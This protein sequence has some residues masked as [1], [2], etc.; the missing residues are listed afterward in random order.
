MP[1]LC[2]RALALAAVL[3]A[4]AVF[5]DSTA[6]RG[7]LK[8]LKYRLLGPA[9][10]G[11]VAR[12]AG[13]PGDPLTYY[14]ATASGGVWKSEDGGFGWKPV[15]DDQPIAS[16]GSI[17]V[18]PS[19]PGVV[20]VG[21]GEANIRG[22]VAPGDGIY[23]SVDAGKTWT[24]VLRLEGQ[25]GKIAVHPRDPDVAFA[26]VL[27][28]AFGPN[29]ERGVYRTRDGGKT[30][31]LVLKKDADTGAS[32]VAIDP[33]NPSVVF[34]GLWQ[35]RRRP[36]QLTSG[37]PGSGLYVSRDGG[38]TWRQLDD[39]K[40]GLPEGIWGKVGVAVAPSDPR[41]V[42][43]LIEAEAGGLFRS[44]DGGEKWT[45]VN[46]HH[47][48]R[49]RAWYYTTLTVDPT[50]ADVVWF[51][52]VHLL[53][54]TDGG[55]SLRQVKGPHH[56]DHHDAWV[57]PADPRRV[58]IGND[59]G[60]DLSLNGGESWFA[61]RLPLGQFYHVSVDDSVPYRV[62]GAMQD[63]GTA[64]ARSNTLSSDGITLA[65]WTD[66]GGGEAGHTASQPGDPDVVYAGEYLGYISRW[67]RALQ[68]P[69]D[70]SAY[71]MNLSGHGDEDA[72]YRFQWTAPIATSPH[73]PKVVYH[74][75]NVLL[76]TTD[77]GQSWA[78]I[79]P[80]LT[81]NDK[82]RQKWTGGPITGDNTGVEYYCT[83]FAIAESPRQQ[84][85]I[86]VGSDDGLVQLTRDGGGSWTNVTPKGFP[87]W[88]TISMI[89]PSPFDAAT[90]YVVVDAHR[91]D[92]LRPYL[93]KTGDYGRS[94]QSLAGGLPRDVYLHAV[95]ED[96]K[97]RGT[98]Y[99]GTE[100]GVLFSRDDGASWESLKLNLPTVAVHD[101]Q[102]KGDD[103]VLGT[104]GR[105]LWILDDLTPVRG[106]TRSVS[107]APVHLFPPA[108]AVRWRYHG[109]F[110]DEGPGSNPPAAAV[111][112][113]WL[114]A[115]A[116][117]VS[118][119]VLDAGGQVIRSLTSKPPEPPDEE[120]DAPD[121]PRH[122]KK[123]EPL[124][125]GPGLHRVRWDLRHEG[126]RR[127][128]RIKFEGADPEQGPLAVPGTY[129]LRLTVDDQTRT[130]SLELRPD[131]R[132]DVRLPALE[133]ALQ[134]G[135]ELRG[136]L[137]G[138]ADMVREIRSARAQLQARLDALREDAAS[139]AWTKEAQAVLD[140]VDALEGKLHNPTAKVEYDIL[141]MRGGTRVYSRLAPLYGWAT[142]A[143]GAPTQGMREVH[144]EL[145][146]ELQGYQAEWKDVVAAARS[147]LSTLALPAA[148]R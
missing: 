71:P 124:P 12:V 2:R 20:Y 23:K 91:L 139:A 36:W 128:P 129:A 38:D 126:A 119:E 89:E 120:E 75:A 57:D 130:T 85:L 69:R 13:V 94:W 1:R 118:L 47:A 67:E 122:P 144:A 64:Q 116:K 87:E 142:E 52:Q 43:A 18:A 44:D 88:S 105:S 136:E 28:H 98:L 6:E 74:G 51:P 106:L 133:E 78:A 63:L 59:G 104:H 37:G 79:S 27:G 101:L 9:V 49:Q 127:I 8:E 53:R 117:S 115:E 135:L 30:W 103:L 40:Q 65:D 60:V 107:D 16:I 80:D 55:R 95:R 109:A 42:Y 7:P 15:F 10:G 90:A 25:I 83:I 96:P 33:S 111:V 132:L 138:V 41:R 148:A 56:G 19:E 86:W 35:A 137:D 61:P 114:K 93:F 100:R 82:S 113:Y 26:A 17:A 102:V 97:Q 147:A 21:S 77:G 112:D 141:A 108:G 68:V 123:R 11:R 84:G 46:D 14:A 81:R 143:D 32:D 140:R 5:A 24:H 145:Q 45:R 31:T 22:N 131:P 48:L 125:T 73:D 121:A 3:L 39:P 50:D 110:Q 54:T 146:K 92:D 76:R 4:P 66:V 72:R 58:L 134:L 29:P 62:A 70:V 34:A 99:L